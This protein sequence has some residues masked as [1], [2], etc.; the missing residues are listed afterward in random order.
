LC[1]EAHDVKATGWIVLIA[2]VFLKTS[3]YTWFTAGG[4]IRIAHYDVVDDVITLK[5]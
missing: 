1:C 3:G 2:E 4:A 5:L